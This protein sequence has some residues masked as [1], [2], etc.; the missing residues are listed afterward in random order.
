MRSCQPAITV[1]SVTQMRRFIQTVPSPNE[2]A[3]TTVH[4]APRPGAVRWLKFWLNKAAS[5]AIPKLSAINL[6]NDSGSFNIYQ[7]NNI[8]Q[9]G[10]V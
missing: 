10:I 1:G 2:I 6:F 7:A 9:R 3:P 8:A 4:A 5:P